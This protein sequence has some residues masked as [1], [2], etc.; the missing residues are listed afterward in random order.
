MTDTLTDT[1]S[2]SPGATFDFSL[3]YQ[4]ERAMFS[5]AG[6]DGFFKDVNPAFERMLGISRATLLKSSMFEFIVPEDI[7]KTLQGISDLQT[8]GDEVA[9]ENRW[10]HVDGT[11]HWL[12]WVAKYDLATRLWYATARDVTEARSIQQSMHKVQER[13]RLALSVAQAG[14]WELDIG[15]ERLLVD[16]GTEVLLGLQPGQF[17]GDFGR[18]LRIVHR[19]DR[20][21]VLQVLRS[22]AGQE[23][24][25]ETDFRLSDESEGTRYLALRGRVVARDRRSRPLQAIGIVFDITNQKVLEEQLLALVMYDSLT[26]VRNRRSFDQTLRREWSRAH[27]TRRPVSVLM[28]DVDWFKSYNDLLGHQAGDE[29]LSAVARSLSESLGRPT[30]LLA[31]YGGEEFVALLSD[32]DASQAALAGEKLLDSIRTLRIP[33]PG[34]PLGF[35]TVSIGAASVIPTE[36]LKSRDLLSQADKALYQAKAAGRNQQ[37]PS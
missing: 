32:T 26:G 35:V 2:P 24:L 1:A 18:M 36:Q 20:R 17:D 31:R 11:V 7:P 22:I 25:L 19:K 15:R 37:L 33:H 3:L 34:S 29:A 28:I 4:A 5:V 12:E 9:F 30:D 6:P 27:R 13:L 21:N 14:S 23:G 10:R 8:G 16:A